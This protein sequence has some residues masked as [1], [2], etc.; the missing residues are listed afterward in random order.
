MVIMNF[1]QI[2]QTGQSLKSFDNSW[3]GRAFL[4]TIAWEKVKEEPLLGYG[5]GVNKR[6]SQRYCIFLW[7]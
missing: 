6:G 1:L 3:T 4:W 2:R 7:L 5:Y